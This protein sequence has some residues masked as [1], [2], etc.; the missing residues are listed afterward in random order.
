MDNF[1]KF[2]DLAKQR[3]TP[4]TRVH[5]QNPMRSITRKHQNQVARRYGYEAKKDDPVID[6]IVKNK[7]YGKW[8]IGGAAAQR[9]LKTYGIK[10]IAGK[11]YTKAINKT[12]ININFDAQKNLFNLSRIKQ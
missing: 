1:S 6:N 4:N 10:H 9:I 7:K 8:N 5:H 2:F 12:G 3:A 11:N